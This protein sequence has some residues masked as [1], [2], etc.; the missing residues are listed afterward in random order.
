MEV[1]DALALGVD[2]DVWEAVAVEG[3]GEAA[4]VEVD[5]GVAESASVKEGSGVDISREGDF[6]SRVR[7]GSGTSV[8]VGCG[9]RAAVGIAVA[10]TW[11]VGL[12]AGEKSLFATDGPNKADVAVTTNS[13]NDT[14]SHCHPVT[15]RARRVR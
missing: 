6:D 8:L 15:M 11:T 10:S 12:G 9:N 13:T 7:V 14:I 5:A 1:T 2:V 4:S 3:M